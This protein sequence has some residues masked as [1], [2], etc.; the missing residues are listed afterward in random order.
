MLEPVSLPG[1]TK[2]FCVFVLGMSLFLRQLTLP[3]PPIPAWAEPQGDEFFS[4]SVH[5]LDMHVTYK[6]PE[7]FE[8][9]QNP[10]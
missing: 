4:E 2:G 7:I 9:F 5:S 1:F 8:D 6:F 3:Q 10:L